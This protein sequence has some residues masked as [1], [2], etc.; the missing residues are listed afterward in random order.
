[1]SRPPKQP[2]RDKLHPEDLEPYDAVI[3][4][5]R[6][7]EERSD[8]APEDHFDAGPYWGALLN[9]PQL[10]ALAAQLGTFVRT[11]GDTE[12]S[13]SHTE[14]EF[15]DQVLSVDWDTNVV[16]AMHVP[17]AVAT[18]VRIEAIEALRGGH[19]ED[20]ND[21]ERLLAKYIRQAVSGT[22]DDAT[23]EAMDE[24]LGTKGLVEYTGF[25]LW[26][27]WIMRMMQAFNIPAPTNQEIDQLVAGL[28]DGSVAVPDFRQRIR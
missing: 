11:V 4:R 24:R 20:L 25:V 21:D 23:W 16:L 2:T 7:M 3:N 15:V 14:R 8:A 28:K 26:L 1:M 10:C 17:D 19:E 22:V 18:G 5:L 9:S 13:Y 12:G 6:S 27:Q